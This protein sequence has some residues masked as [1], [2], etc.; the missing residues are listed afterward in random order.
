M[1]KQRSLWVLKSYFLNSKKNNQ[2]G[3]TLLECLVA[4]LTLGIAF[5]LNLQ[6]LTL[7]KIGNLKQEIKTGAVALSKGIL[8]DMRYK[9]SD[10]IANLTL[11]KTQ[12]SNQTSFGYIYDAD[13]YV[14]T[15]DPSINNQNQVTSCPT[16]NEEND[17]RYIVVQ[18]IDKKRNNEKVY[19]VQTSFAKLQ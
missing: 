3:F 18:I 14:C 19:T 5:A 13:I 4:V 8:D 2:H 1:N 12:V 10:D 17:I 9:L 7:L 6:F 15:G 16:A 11:G